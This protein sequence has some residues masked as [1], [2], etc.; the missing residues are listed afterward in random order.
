MYINQK[1]IW[2]LTQ[3][4]SNS[5]Q[6]LFT[7]NEKS[8]EVRLLDEEELITTTK[9]LIKSTNLMPIG[10][11]EQLL[12]IEGRESLRQQLMFGE[13]DKELDEILS[14]I[15]IIAKNGGVKPLPSGVLEPML[16]KSGYDPRSSPQ[17]V[18][19]R[20]VEV[21]VGILVQS[22]AN[23]QL[24]TMDYDM[25]CWL[26]MSWR[27]PRLA[28][29]L[30]TP[31]LIND[32]IFLKKIWR[33][34]IHFV[35]ARN[36]LFHRVTRLNFYI[37][38]FPMSGKVFFEARLYVKP[39]SQLILCK[40]P[41]DSQ[42]LQLRISSIASTNNSVSLRWF[43]HQSDAIRIHGRLQLPELYIAGLENK[44]C[45][46]Q[47]KT[48]NFSCL[49]ARFLMKRSIGVLFSWISVWL[50]EEFVEGR[51]FVALTNYLFNITYIAESS[52]AKETLPRFTML[53]ALT[54]IGLEHRS[55]Q[56]KKIIT[57]KSN[58][59][60]A[61]KISILLSDS[62]LHHRNALRLDT[63]FK[64]MYPVIFFIFLFIYIFVVIEGDEN[65]CIQNEL[66]QQNNQK[67]K[68]L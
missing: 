57:E 4:I 17:F 31:I 21:R 3:L 41:H 28:L 15:E 46:S 9:T 7:R 42:I 62:Q 47:R 55:R 6:Q 30:S 37:F 63:F 58:E 20:P 66:N 25:D 32:E 34:D 52:S 24:S 10:L 45:Q 48:G 11:N 61:Y 19:G 22:I 16:N 68:E 38:I 26:R 35:N 13:D 44:N 56:L 65:K 23:F 59:I 39:K 2:I 64:V 5:N 18:Q 43:S 27:D 36:S 40:Y 33:P 54:V 53:Q 29:N 50:P 49:E 60:S 1:Y 67:H 8:I 51:V 12:S 14:K